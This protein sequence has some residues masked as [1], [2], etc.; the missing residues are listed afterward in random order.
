M[1]N[2]RTLPVRLLE[3]ADDRFGAGD[4]AW[5]FVGDLLDVLDQDD[6]RELRLAMTS[7]DFGD[8]AKRRTPIILAAENLRLANHHAEALALRMLA[9]RC[10]DADEL[11]GIYDAIE[12]RALAFVSTVPV[13]QKDRADRI[14]RA[15]EVWEAAALGAF[16]AD[17]R[18]LF[19]RVAEQGERPI[20]FNMKFVDP[21]VAAA[22][23]MPLELLLLKRWDDAIE[24]AWQRTQLLASEG[25][26]LMI[27]A[28]FR[29]HGYP[30]RDEWASAIDIVVQSLDQRGYVE[31]A[32]AWRMLRVDAQDPFSVMAMLP[33][34]YWHLDRATLDE[35]TKSEL[36]HRLHYWNEI[37]NGKWIDSEFSVFR[38]AGVEGP[39]RS[40]ERQAAGGAPKGIWAAVNKEPEEGVVSGE[41][42]LLP[43]G[44]PPGIIVIPKAGATTLRRD[45][46]GEYRDLVGQH[47]SFVMTPNLSEVRAA[48]LREYPHAVREIGVLL[49]D[50]KQGTP[51][52]MKPMLIV[53]EPG[54]GKS[55][56]VRR[57]GEALGL[58]V[59]RYDASAA[60]DNMFGGVSKSWS[61]TVPSVPT[62]ALAMAKSANAI[63]MV[64]EIE[65]AGSS[66]HNGNLWQAMGP[67]L[68][69]ETSSRY[70]DVSL[71]CEVNLA[72]VSTIATA[73]SLD[74]LPAFLLDRFRIIRWPMPTLAHLPQLAAGVL[75][76]IERET[77][78]QGFNLPLDPDELEAIG[79][80]WARQKFSMRRL[81]RMIEA[82]LDAR[83]ATAPRH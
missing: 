46:H 64:D 42:K 70:R 56:V 3:L 20:D 74:G 8:H 21:A 16:P 2:N 28:L 62:R 77:D 34:L 48:L 19:D 45:T 11:D 83:A 15:L 51:A 47:L 75:A 73:N 38:I 31:H 25:D 66:R 4:I 33:H 54:G 69:R 76:E 27:E 26:V 59:Y 22:L 10:C 58:F 5:V 17:E 49:R 44:L 61:S 36:R 32:T 37:A 79:R 57:L 9:V 35:S 12:K 41:T 23:P 39:N 72:H 29:Q 78:E 18:S 13:E 82:T 52:V 1:T 68:E 6:R 65:K 53:G 7:E 40:K 63:V 55:R 80:L 50:L 14:V 43:R 30:S 60:M 67:F 24:T 71:D 81:R